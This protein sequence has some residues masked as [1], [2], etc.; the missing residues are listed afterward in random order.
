MKVLISL[1][2]LFGMVSA[3]YAATPVLSLEKT[4]QKQNLINKKNALAEKRAAIEA[5]KK[6]NQDRLAALRAQKNQPK[7]NTQNIAKTTTVQ[8]TT[9]TQ[10]TK[11]VSTAAS[12]TV[13]TPASQTSIAWVDMTRV[14]TTWL[15][16]YNSGRAAK[17]LGAYSYDSR[18]DGTA[19]D[20]NIVFAG[21]RG[22]NFH[23]RSPGDGY[24]N[25]NVINKWFQARGINPPVVWW[26]NHS[27]NVSWGTYSCSSSD[28][29]DE[30]ISAIQ[31]SYTFFI[32]SPVHAKSVFQPNFTKIGFDII[33]VPNERRYYITVHF[34]TK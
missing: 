11:V 5:R 19:H 22:T 34:M 27:E 9:A 16:W 12:T 25:Y 24:Y 6:A 8:T 28:C 33:V 30:L 23:E 2:L 31:S 10:T 7:T 1:I 3:S 17:W 13:S 32:N 15:S 29:T 4:M 18:L 20:W 26:V 14:R 21:S